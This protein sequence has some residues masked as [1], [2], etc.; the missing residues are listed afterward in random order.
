MSKLREDG[1]EEREE[2][3][4]K[5]RMSGYVCSEVLIELSPAS[6]GG[7]GAEPTRGNFPTRVRQQ[8]IGPGREN[9]L[10]E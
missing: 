8:L 5:V 6:D 2:V 7:G 3:K 4:P 1:D 10:S 9:N